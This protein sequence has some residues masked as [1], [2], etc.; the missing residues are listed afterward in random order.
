M[1]ELSFVIMV[2]LAVAGGVICTVKNNKKSSIIDKILYWGVYS[3]FYVFLMNLTRCAILRGSVLISY[4]NHRVVQ[5][6][7]ILVILI[8]YVS[9]KEVS[10]IIIIK[11]HGMNHIYYDKGYP[12]IFI[13]INAVLF[14]I[15]GILYYFQYNT[16]KKAIYGML[17]PDV[18]AETIFISI[19][20]S[21]IINAV[22]CL[23]FADSAKEH[24]KQLVRN[25]SGGY[26]SSF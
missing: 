9:F 8:G 14:L 15:R 4:T 19:A 1:G 5:A 26:S 10:D 16:M 11:K 25:L 3:L 7:D 20:V 13:L 18:I 2:L 24:R 12:V 17:F 23:F 22:L 6:A 21:V